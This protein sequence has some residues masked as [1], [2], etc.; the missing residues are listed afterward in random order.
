MIGHI[1][2]SNFRWLRTYSSSFPSEA[3]VAD[4]M[5]KTI[6]LVSQ[7]KAVLQILHLI[8]K[9][10]YQSKESCDFDIA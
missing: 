9:K 2:K 8:K 6:F 7:K 3:T 4:F 10:Q 1:N 5:R